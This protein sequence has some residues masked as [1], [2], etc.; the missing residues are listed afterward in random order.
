MTRRLQPQSE[1]MGCCK[2][3]K[4]FVFLRLRGVLKL[5]GVAG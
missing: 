4:V 5:V 2:N 1:K 3:K